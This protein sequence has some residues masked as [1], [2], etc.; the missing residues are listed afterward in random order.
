MKK[1]VT[2]PIDTDKINKKVEI[3]NYN[4]ISYDFDSLYPH[5]ITDYSEAFK[6]EFLRKQREDKLNQINERN[7]NKSN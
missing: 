4:T 7:K 5:T 1:I 6:K 2:S 3:K